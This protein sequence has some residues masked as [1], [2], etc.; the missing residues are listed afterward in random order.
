MCR[1][2]WL[3]ISAS[4]RM[5]KELPYTKLIHKVR[6]AI[7]LTVLSN[8]RDNSQYAI[9]HLHNDSYAP[10][11][12]LEIASGGHVQLDYD[13]RAIFICELSSQKNKLPTSCPL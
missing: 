1:H 12:G 6:I 4:G 13:G 8:R 7:N 2:L 9:K 3:R 11:K 5:E 10:V